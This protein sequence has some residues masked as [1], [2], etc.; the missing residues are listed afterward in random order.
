MSTLERP[1]TPVSRHTGL[2]GSHPL[3]SFYVL[4]LA[5]SWGAILIAVGLG[6]GGFSATP[7]Q[8]QAA[9]PYAVP[10][11]LA[12]PGIAGLLLTGVL[13]GRAGFHELRTRLVTWRVGARWYVIAILTAPL[14]ITAVLL[15]LSLISPMFLPRI[16]TSSGTAALLLMGLAVGLPTGVLEELGWTGFAVPRLRLRYGVLG[17]GL[18]VGVLWGAWHLPVNYWAS[19][20]TSGE[21]S[22]AVWAPLWLVGTFVGQL[23]AFRVLMVWIYER[24]DGSLPVAMLMHASLATFTIILFPPLAVVANLISGFACA[25][26]IWLVVA[27]VGVAQGGHLSRQPLSYRLRERA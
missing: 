3:L 25:A 24:T 7:Q 13:Y 18:I 26:A 1:V 15:A 22:L 5:I 10:A 17:T 23:T 9:I 12:G 21:I 4:T 11:M 14:L 8:L 6:P 27:A 20:V 16:F 19:G 2:I